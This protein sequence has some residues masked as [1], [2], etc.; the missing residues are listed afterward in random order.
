MTSL[1]TILM[2]TQQYTLSTI[3]IIV[4]MGLIACRNVRRIIRRQVP[5]VRRRLDRQ[6][7]K[8]VLL[9][10]SFLIIFNTPFVI[11]RVYSINIIINPTD[12]MRI[13]VERLV[14]A[15]INSVLYLNYAVNFY[16]F[17]LSSSQY[18]RQVRYVLIKKYWQQ[19][20]QRFH[21]H[22]NQIGPSNASPVAS[23]ELE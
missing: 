13:A 5:I 18:R 10:V 2:F 23:I 20:K 19:W 16:I 1:S 14:Q 8:L 11:Y 22:N 6:L 21:P 9:R 15:I 17:W 12:S 7:T 4:I 3:I